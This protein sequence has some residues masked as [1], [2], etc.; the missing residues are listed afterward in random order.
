MH[1]QCAFTFH[2][3]LSGSFCSASH[4][5]LNLIWGYPQPFPCF[6]SQQGLLLMASSVYVCC[7][8]IMWGRM[9]TEL[10]VRR[11][12]LSGKLLGDVGWSS[13]GHEEAH[14]SQL[15]P[16]A[17]TGG[18]HRK[19]LFCILIGDRLHPRC[20]SSSAHFCIHKCVWSTA[21]LMPKQLSLSWWPSAFWSPWPKPACFCPR[22]HEQIPLPVIDSTCMHVS[23]YSVLSGS[24]WPT[25]R[26]MSLPLPFEEAWGCASSWKIGFLLLSQH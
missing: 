16:F 8:Y 19:Q 17:V 9:F 15:F 3:F 10:E 11:R 13:M 18:V 14:K 25:C 1:S 12:R 6:A 7:G 26:I 2:R 20:V 24:P 23:V 5:P 21:H 22:C 4:S